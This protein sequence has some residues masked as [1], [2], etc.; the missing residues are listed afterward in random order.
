MLLARSD[1][2]A[3][4]ERARAEERV[5]KITGTAPGV[6]LSGLDFSSPYRTDLGIHL[7]VFEDI[8][9]ASRM[10]NRNLTAANLAMPICRVPPSVD[11]F[12]AE[13]IFPTPCFG[14]L[15]WTMRI[16]ATHT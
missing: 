2:E 4:F 12:Y 6:D 10:Q 8:D 9:L 16:W 11:R 5:S 3:E 1:F 14:T 15:N 7:G 13:R